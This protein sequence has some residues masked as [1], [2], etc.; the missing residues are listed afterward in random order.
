MI[1]GLPAFGHGSAAQDRVPPSVAVRGQVGD[2]RPDLGD[3][4][5]VGLRRPS[6]G[7]GLPVLGSL[8]QV[9]AGEPD[10]SA[11]VFSSGGHSLAEQPVQLPHLAL[12][13]SMDRGRHDLLLGAGRRQRTLRG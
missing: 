7:P 9:G 1:R 11:A 5:L 8:G 6:N 4:G 12:E 3:E 10:Q 13:R 2:H